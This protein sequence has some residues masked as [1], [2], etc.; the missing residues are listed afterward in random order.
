[1]G[2]GGSKGKSKEPSGPVWLNHFSL[3]I[4]LGQGGFG[5]VKA[6]EKLYGKDKGNICA[7]IILDKA[8]LRKN[9]SMVQAALMERH[10]LVKVHTPHICNLRYAFQDQE[11]LYLVLDVALG[12]DLT[13][14]IKHHGPK[15]HPVTKNKIFPEEWIQY[16]AASMV[17][18]LGT[19]H[20]NNIIMRD[21][22]PDNILMDATVA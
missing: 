2:G 15:T 1:M 14:Q 19:L 10:V 22:K 4:T 5:V 12:G 13:F 20:A 9:S 3:E 8:Q 21:M 16:Y 11:N 18:A 7:R 6:V 17:L